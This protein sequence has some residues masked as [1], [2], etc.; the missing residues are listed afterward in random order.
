MSVK[1]SCIKKWYS[2]QNVVK[3]GSKKVYKHNTS[4]KQ[5]C[6]KIMGTYKIKGI[7]MSTERITDPVVGT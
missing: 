1:K 5:C 4:I 7:K 3:N 2:I 6:R